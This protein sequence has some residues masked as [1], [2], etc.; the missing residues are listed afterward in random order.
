[1]RAVITRVTSASVAV[2]CE[3]RAKIGKG[4]LVL[5]GVLDTDTEADA[6]YLAK[7]TAQLRIFGDAE[8]KLNISCSQAGGEILAASNLHPLRGWAQGQPAQ[9][10]PGRAPA[11]GG[12][13]LRIF[14][15]ASAGAGLCCSN[16]R[17]RRGHAARLSQR[18]AGDA[19]AGERSL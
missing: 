17:V 4:L 10:H 14:C 5:L 15:V 13:A 7:K 19:S 11:K 1:M 6:E 18:R 3:E 8:G 9:L 2:G 12:A 16:R